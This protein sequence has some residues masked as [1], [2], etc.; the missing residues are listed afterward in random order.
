[1]PQLEDWD[2]MQMYHQFKA[3]VGLALKSKEVE[4]VKNLPDH[5]KYHCALYIHNSLY[6]FTVCI[7]SA[8]CVALLNIIAS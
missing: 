8:V 3:S 7:N 5:C 4:G 2:I 1:M 6:V